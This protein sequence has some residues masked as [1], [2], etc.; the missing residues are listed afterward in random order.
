MKVVRGGT[1]VTEAGTCVADV[2]IVDGRV[3]AIGRDLPGDELLD[4]RGLHVFPGF[5]DAHVHFCDEGQADWEDFATAG[6][7]AVAGGV[8][9]VMDMPLND[10]PTV[11][12]EAFRTRLAA[13]GPKA[14][15]DY[16]LWAGCVPGNE[17]EM[18]AMRDLGARAF[19]AFMIRTP[20]YP[21]CD[22]AALLTAM[23]EAARLGLPLGVHAQSDELVHARVAEMRAAGRDDAAAHAWA[24]DEFSEYESIHRAIALAAEA[25]CRLH[26]LHVDTPLAL[27]EIA[28]APHVVGE[29]QIGFITLDEEDY[30]R[31]GTWARF[32]PPL[33]PR[34]RVELL[35]DAIADG[36]LEYVISDHSGYPPELKDVDSIW[37]AADG[38][39]A[40]QTCYPA[41]LSEGVHRR[42]LSL[43]RF[44]TLS[45]ARAARLYGLYPRKG[46]LLPLRSDAD[47]AVVDLARTWTLESSRLLY[48][49]PWSVQEGARFTGEVLAT[50][51]RGE[52]VYADGEVLA[53]PGSGE[54]T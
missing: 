31:H 27:A 40:V 24:H 38:V 26:V 22:S 19:K 30:L 51:R 25:G 48:K 44:V 46:A 1:V 18:E 7:A 12:G 34:E 13:I 42:G 9:T 39:P 23:R 52:L 20:D 6:R 41:L 17:G 43:E 35:W 36:T 8:T 53:Q 33:R 11:T 28:A 32:S 14:I 21:H 29:A 49:H 50:I 3:A 4:A 54:M 37:D 47:L 16:A 15:T 10:P 2:G 5:F 45:S